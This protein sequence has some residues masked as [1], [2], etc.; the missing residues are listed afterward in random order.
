MCLCEGW[1]KVSFLFCQYSRNCSVRKY[2]KK[3]F[4]KYFRPVFGLESF[5]L[6]VSPETHTLLSAVLY[7][8]SQMNGDVIQ[9]QSCR[10]SCY[11]WRQNKKQS[12]PPLVRNQTLPAE[13]WTEMVK[14]TSRY[15]LSRH[16]SFC[17]I[18][19]VRITSLFFFPPLC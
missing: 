11:G 9:N 12:F 18:I 7:R 4:L 3:I 14:V 1:R 16:F 15:L 13:V 8:S 5:A 10:R 19:Y 2:P 6:F 17:S